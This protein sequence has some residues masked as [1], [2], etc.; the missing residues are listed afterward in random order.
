MHSQRTYSG[1]IHACHPIRQVAPPP[2]SGPI[3]EREIHSFI[4]RRY[5]LEAQYAIFGHAAGAAAA[6]SLSLK[7]PGT[8][9]DLNVT[10]LQAVLLSQKQLLKV[11][12]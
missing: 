9:Q 8:V 2:V 1:D 10:A 6:L 4:P 3:D 7:S 12:R 5:R 11:D